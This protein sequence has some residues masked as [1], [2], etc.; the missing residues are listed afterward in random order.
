M[1]I[2]TATLLFAFLLSFIL[3]FF[4]YPQPYTNYSPFTPKPYGK[5]VLFELPPVT[6]A[7]DFSYYLEKVP[8]VY[9]FLGA[10]NEEK[11]IMQT[12]HHEEFNIDEDALEIGTVLNIQYALDFL[13]E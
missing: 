13:N 10:G 9:I 3:L 12:N 1:I 5:D 7:E 8:G 6:G 2:F 11:G 4:H